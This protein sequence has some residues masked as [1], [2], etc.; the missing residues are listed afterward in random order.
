M[1][2][3]RLM[4]DVR[5]MRDVRSHKSAPQRTCLHHKH[6][7]VIVMAKE[8]SLRLIIVTKCVHIQMK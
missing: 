6:N 5:P 1:R 8:L 4:R 7:S 2:D 3:V